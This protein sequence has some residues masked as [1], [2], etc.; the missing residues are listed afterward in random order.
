[1]DPLLARRL[2]EL[3]VPQGR[4]ISIGFPLEY[5]A[6]LQ[7]RYAQVLSRSSRDQI[8]VGTELAVDRISD[9]LQ[10]WP[11]IASNAQTIATTVVERA[12]E[13]IGEATTQLKD[14]IQTAADSARQGLQETVVDVRENVETI[15]EDVRGFIGGL[16][17][18]GG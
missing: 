18:R 11:G 9:G 17:G 14:N 13:A 2:P 6:L 10:A 5:E 7:W 3:V 4:I 16:F 15:V 8:G 1:M 12:Q